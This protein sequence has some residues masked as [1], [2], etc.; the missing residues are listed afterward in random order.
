MHKIF[1]S[2]PNVPFNLSNE[3]TTTDK[4]HQILIVTG[5]SE[6]DCALIEF[7]IKGECSEGNWLPFKDCCGQVTVTSDCNN[8]I[9]LSL[10]LTYRVF[11]SNEDDNHLSDPYWFSNV[12]IFTVSTNNG[13]ELSSLYNSCCGDHSTDNIISELNRISNAVISISNKL[14]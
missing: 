6:G 4:R 13:I 5:L 12:E 9:I 8:F 14:G 10:P 7:Y 1:P 3:F 2:S 11:L